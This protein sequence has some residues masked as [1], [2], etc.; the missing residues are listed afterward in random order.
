M[1]TVYTSS[2]KGRGKAEDDAR[3]HYGPLRGTSTLQ[4]GRDISRAIILQWIY[5]RG[6]TICLF[7]TF[8]W[9]CRVSVGM[10]VATCRI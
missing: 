7:F 8:I 10:L 2:V 4:G 5:S 9:L 3:I 6:F 1:N